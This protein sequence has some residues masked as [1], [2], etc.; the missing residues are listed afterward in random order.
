MPKYKNWL[1]ATQYYYPERGAA[2]V[3]LRAFAQELKKAGCNVKVLTG[4]PN[5]PEGILQNGFKGKFTMNDT[6]DGI[7]VKRLWLYPAAG[8][9][10]IKRLFNYFTF[11]FHALFHLRAARKVDIIFIE[12][13]P[14]FLSYYGL[15]A[16][17]L[18]KKPYIYNT[19]DLQVEQS[20]ER[21]WM[22]GNIVKLARRMEK[23]LMMNSLSVSTVT[24]AF[25]EHFIKELNIPREKMSFLPNG[26]DLDFMHPLPYD[27]GY[28]KR[29]G[30]EGKKVFTFAGTIA[31]N[32]GADVIL[33]AAKLTKEHN[34]IV[35][36]IAGSGAERATLTE[37]AKKEEINNVVFTDLPFIDVPTVMSITYAALVTVRDMDVAKKIRS[38]KTFPALACGVPVIYS[39]EGESA[40]IV[41]QNGCGVQTAPGDGADLARAVLELAANPVLREQFSK[42]GIALT[43]REFSWKVITENWLKEVEAIS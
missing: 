38:A 31:Y 28:A 15:F 29:I 4:M 21:G 40:D 18:Y 23:Q 36:L 16:K 33:E 14:V 30:I 6:V 35:Y 8:R 34:D 42:A 9:N 39:G 41:V 12:S 17:W 11:T 3:R 24:H 37:K 19:P 22:L 20:G 26:V 27:A 5:Y 25:I 32:H 7:P 1:I 2:Q 43:E 10:I 13:Q